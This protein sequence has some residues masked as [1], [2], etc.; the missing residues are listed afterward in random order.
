MKKRQ[1]R[2]TTVILEYLKDIPKYGNDV[3]RALLC[4]G[5]ELTC[6][7]SSYLTFQEME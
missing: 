4:F 1:V 7:K 6:A 5:E 2:V 3:C